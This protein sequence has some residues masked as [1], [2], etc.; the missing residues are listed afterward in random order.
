MEKERKIESFT[1]VVN[2]SWSPVL[3]ITV[4]PK[5]KKVRIQ[6]KLDVQDSENGSFMS[7]FGV[8]KEWRK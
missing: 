7:D 6:I 3:R 8:G 2:R 5:E 4:E 1:E